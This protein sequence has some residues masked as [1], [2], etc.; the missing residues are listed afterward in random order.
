MYICY[1]EHSLHHNA[2]LR[3][4]RY[5]DECLVAELEGLDGEVHCMAI[6][7]GRRLIAAAGATDGMIVIWQMS[8]SNEVLTEIEAHDDQ[9]FDLQFSP[10][11]HR[12]ET[13]PHRHLVTAEEEEEGGGG[14]GGGGPAPRPL[15]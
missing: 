3:P 2:I 12:Y 1:T 11:G 4:P 10:D 14:G 5:A 9:I 15:R 6:H 8:D 13:I 7:R